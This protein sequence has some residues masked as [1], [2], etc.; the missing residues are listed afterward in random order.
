MSRPSSAGLTLAAVVLVALNL[1]G[2]IAAVPPLLGELQEEIG[3]STAGASLLTTLPVLLFA[4]A[5]PGAVRLGRRVG[6]GSAILVGLALVVLGSV[7]RVLGGPVALLVGTL[8]LG[9]GMTIGNV[10]VPVVAKRDF[11]ERAPQLIGAFTASLAVGASLTAALT[12][13]VAHQ[14]GWRVGLGVW[15]VLAVLAAPLWWLAVARHERQERREERRAAADDG[16]VTT[17]PAV[18]TLW[19]YRLAW[20]VAVALGTQ[21]ALYYS[22]TTW[23]PTYLMEEV[24]LAQVT[25]GYALSVFQVM[26]IPFTLAVPWLTRRR[27][28]QGWIGCTV[29]VVWILVLLGLAVLPQAWPL[30]VV[31]AGAA[32]GTGFALALT[33]IVLRSADESV[34]GPLSGMSQL[35][36]YSIGAAGPFVVGVLAS[37]TGG[38]A[39]PGLVLIGVAMAAFASMWVAGQD[40]TIT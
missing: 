30:W 29:A 31:V 28:T 35:I 14:F 32:Q 16:S 11:R 21:S 38:W 8:V 22:F 24:G 20:V 19:R 26:G 13:P 25:A 27:P 15:G 6:P 36:G 40:R 3:L 5:A 12:V 34:T 37:A 9:V 23:I 17:R 1:R 18:R 7:A 39:V 2:S 33:L 10:L 4:L